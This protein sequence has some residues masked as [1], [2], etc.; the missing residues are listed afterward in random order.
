MP[1]PQKRETPAFEW[2]SRFEKKSAE[3]VAAVP[4]ALVD[5]KGGL[6]SFMVFI[7]YSSTNHEYASLSNN[8][9]IHACFW[10]EEFLCH[11]VLLTPE[12]APKSG[13]A[14]L[15]F[16][17]NHGSGFLLRLLEKR[18]ANP[19][20]VGKGTFGRLRRLRK[21]IL[22]ILSTSSPMLCIQAR[23]PGTSST[24]NHLRQDFVPASS[25]CLRA[26]KLV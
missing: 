22:S 4:T 17:A 16:S 26:G 18:S 23:T 10:Q 14:N 11:S 1:S 20:H 8:S 21:G 12:G 5:L 7:L 15:G 25:R 9:A 24:R 6:T 19:E 2:R 13:L 3:A